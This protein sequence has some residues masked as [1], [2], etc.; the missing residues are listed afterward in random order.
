M[1]SLSLTVGSSYFNTTKPSL[2]IY[3]ILPPI[4]LRC[5]DILIFQ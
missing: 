5:I 2:T 3:Q 1:F 4:A